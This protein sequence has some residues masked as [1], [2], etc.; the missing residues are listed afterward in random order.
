M[1]EENNVRVENLQMEQ[2]PVMTVD[3]DSN[4]YDNPVEKLEDDFFYEK[5]KTEDDNQIEVVPFHEP[6]QNQP[7]QAGNFE[8]M[9]DNLSSSVAGANNFIA[10]LL[11][12]RKVVAQEKTTLKADQEQFQKQKQE[13]EEYKKA[14]QEE[15][16]DARLKCDNYV[17]AERKRQESEQ[18]QFTT[19]VEATRAELALTEKALKVGNDKLDADKIQF[20]VY[21]DLEEKKIK[22]DREAV[23]LGRNKLTEDLAQ[24]EKEKSLELDKIKKEQQELKRQREQFDQEKAIELERIKNGQEELAIQKEQFRQA[25]E[26]EEKRLELENNNLNQ[27]MARFQELVA[28]FNLGFEQIPEAK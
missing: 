22:N 3:E 11:E 15:I 26:I 10:N 12:Q 25:K 6:V 5:D 19:E 13:F 8:N 9:I 23:E 24:F 4:T 16:N 1:N 7:V 27:S 18:E 21:K 14:Q 2:P 17:R 28:Q 20:E